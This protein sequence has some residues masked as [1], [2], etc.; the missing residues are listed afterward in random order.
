MT[1]GR[2]WQPSPAFL[3]GESHGQRS[4]TGYSPWGHTESDVTEH[5]HTASVYCL[6]LYRLKVVLLLQIAFSE[7]FFWR[8]PVLKSLLNLLQ[9]CFCFTY[10]LFWPRDMWGLSFLTRDQTYTP[11]I[12]RQNLNPWTAREVPIY[13][14]IAVVPKQDITPI[15]WALTISQVVWEG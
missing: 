12:G 11:C 7:D 4:L 6:F 14:F 3:P 15:H 8:G 9:Y 5:I 2:K 13:T 10:R 1:W